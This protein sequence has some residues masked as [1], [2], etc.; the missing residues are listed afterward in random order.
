MRPKNLNNVC[1]YDFLEQYCVAPRS[2]KSW[3]W[4]GDY[5][6]K[7]RMAVKLRIRNKV[8]LITHRDFPETK[9]FNGLNVVTSQWPVECP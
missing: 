1:L 6:S 5:P 4:E 2:K 9:D 8:A 3:E 7:S